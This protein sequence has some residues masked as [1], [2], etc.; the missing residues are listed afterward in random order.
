MKKVK[1]RGSV[2]HFCLFYIIFQFEI[3]YC[4]LLVRL[5]GKKMFKKLKFRI[6]KK[7]KLLGL[8]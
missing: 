8:V 5:H 3:V 4:Y 1:V 6:L 2:L 7:S